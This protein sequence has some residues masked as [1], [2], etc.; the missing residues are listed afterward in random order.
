MRPAPT[1]TLIARLKRE[2]KART[3]LEAISHSAALEQAA[4]SVGYA[5]WHALLHTPVTAAA[6]PDRLVI[7]PVLPRRFDDT[8][9][10]RRSKK[11]LDL[12]W[13]RP[14]ALTRPDGTLLVR[15][16]DGG[17][18]DRSTNYGVAAN[19]EEALQLAT[20]RLAEWKRSRERPMARVRE[21]DRCDLIR[22]P[23]R[24]DLEEEVILED[25]TYDE[26]GEWIKAHA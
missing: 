20:Q 3:R 12:W 19:E 5:S 15:C 22:L 8:P 4:R 10:E 16:L 26:A 11:H 17:A 24:P 6:S 25:V 13:D 23:Q 21:G 14:F 1:K 18:W 2:A 9:N 7:D